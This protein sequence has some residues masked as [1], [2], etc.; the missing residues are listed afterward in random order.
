M[1]HPPFQFW[2]RRHFCCVSKVF[3]LWEC[4]VKTPYG[5]F[6]HRF[7]TRLEAAEYSD[8]AKLALIERGIA[9]P[10]RFNFPRDHYPGDINPLVGFELRR[11][12]DQANDRMNIKLN[13]P[14]K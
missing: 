2:S 4:G 3:D 12:L 13:P 5:T 10:V 11:F 6:K 8:I 14:S 1:N 9:H 7:P